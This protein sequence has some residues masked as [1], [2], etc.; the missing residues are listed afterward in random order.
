[1]K[2]EE[3]IYEALTDIDERY[4]EEAYLTKQE[5]AVG[6]AKWFP[7]FQALP[8]IK[9]GLLVAGLAL[10][11]A[12]GALVAQWIGGKALHA[13]SLVQAG[14][15]P[16]ITSIDDRDEYKPASAQMEAMRDFALASSSLLLEDYAGNVTYSPVSLYYT[17]A[18]LAEGSANETEQLLLENL[19]A[20]NL[21]DLREGAGR[22]LRYY[23]RDG[24]VESDGT[25]TLANSVW[26]AEALDRSIEI[27]DAYLS[28][29]EH[30][31]HADVYQVDFEGSDSLKEIAGWLGENSAIID[32]LAPAVDE[33]TQLVLFNTVDFKALWE[34]HFE[35]H[36]VDD[37]IFYVDSETEVTVPFLKRKE[38]G[39]FYQTETF[40][41]SSLNIQSQAKISFILPADGVSPE[42]LI[43]REDDLDLLISGGEAI[44]GEVTWA[45]P[46]FRTH[47]NLELNKLIADLGLGSLF[48]SASDLSR[49]SDEVN[50]LDFV[51]Q[52]IAFEISDKGVSASAISSLV[53]DGEPPIT[54]TADMVLDRPFIYVITLGDEDVPLFIGICRDPS[55]A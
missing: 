11:L 30:D 6:R 38:W 27:K 28:A 51:R 34:K 14:S 17:L 45:V 12:G 41:R 13:S 42:D 20:S 3:R 36:E 40:L 50:F 1:M 4:I 23:Y 35:A 33:F 39:T 54:S 53:I 49:L 47:N 5:D 29:V 16:M 15:D 9:K 21:E 55:I 7:R 43:Q 22:F 2:R 18:L 37:D 10:L 25:L 46:T 31:Y 24:S 32:P 52:E 48:D 44:H 26:I 19:G 8:K